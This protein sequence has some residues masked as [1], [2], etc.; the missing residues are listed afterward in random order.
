MKRAPSSLSRRGGSV[1]SF[2]VVIGSFRTV[3][4]DLLLLM[5]SPR[6]FIDNPSPAYRLPR[7]FNTALPISIRFGGCWNEPC[8]SP[9]HDTFSPAPGLWLSSAS[10]NIVWVMTN[11]VQSTPS[12]PVSPSSSPA[13]RPT[14]I[15]GFPRC[16]LKFP[17]F[18]H[19][20]SEIFAY[21]SIQ[22]NLSTN[23]CFLLECGRCGK[24]ISCFFAYPNNYSCLY[25]RLE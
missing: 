3:I 24:I 22:S 14:A 18:L 7:K 10:N 11:A 1:F 15:A 23:A 12:L 20:I 4:D 2:A 19:P 25:R 21:I 13:S 17:S 6:R 5:D 8:P 9:V 16:P